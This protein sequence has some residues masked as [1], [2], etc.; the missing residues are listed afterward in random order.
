MTIDSST[1]SMINIL[2]SGAFDCHETAH[3]YRIIKGTIDLFLSL[4]NGTSK[5]YP[6]C[7]FEAGD[8]I[9]GLQGV[10]NDPEWSLIASG[11]SET[12]LE[13]LSF[14][15]L[16]K[17]LDYQK[18]SAHKE[19]PLQVWQHHFLH[20]LKDHK[21]KHKI[22]NPLKMDESLSQNSLFD[23][24]QTIYPQLIKAPRLEDLKA[25][26]HVKALR[27]LEEDEL[28]RSYKDM[29]SII[30][31]IPV[32]HKVSARNTLTPSIHHITDFYNI[33]MPEEQIISNLNDV[34]LAT[35]VQFREISLTGPWW[36]TIT[37]PVLLKDINDEHFCVAMPGRRGDFNLF[38]PKNQTCEKL[39]AETAQRFIP[40]AWQAYH[41][42]PQK[43]LQLKELLSFSIQGSRLDLLR[44]V[45]V[46]SLA[47][48]LALATPWFTSFIFDYI[49]PNGEITQLYQIILGLI[50]AAC[51]SGLFGLV[52]AV[53]LLRLSSKI[54]LNLEVGIW[55]RLIRL[56]VS[57]FKNYT[58]GELVVRAMAASGMRH[59][60]GGVVISSIL[61]GIFSLFSFILLFYYD[62]YLAMIA[63]AGTL[64]LCALT[65][66]ISIRQYKFYKI[67]QDKAAKLSGMVVQL[68]MGIAKIQES[69]KEKMAFAHWA[70]Q[71]TAI[72]SESYKVNWLHTL[73]STFNAAWM[74]LLYLAIFACISTLKKDQLSLGSFLAFNAALGQFTAGMLGLTNAMTSVIGSLPMLKQLT[75]IIENLPEVHSGKVDPGKLKGRISA[76]NLAFRYAENGPMILKSISLSIEA[77]QYIAITGPS[78]SGKSTL[79]RL[80]LGFNQPVHG[81]IFFDEHDITQLNPQRVRQQCGVVLQNSMLMTGS[82]Y[83]NIV[84]SAV[85]S[86]EDAMRA[87]E[88][89]GMREDIEAMPMGL[90]TLVSERGGSLSGGQRQRLL[91]ARALARNPR[92]LFFDEATSALD[93]RTQSIV[94]RS[95][96]QLAVTRIVIAHRLTTIEKADLILVL[97]KGEVV[98]QGTYQELMS[99]PGLFKEMA[100]RQLTT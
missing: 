62:V 12:A 41:P 25:L 98:Q 20:Y 32:M 74:P 4:R 93:N 9:V 23:F 81:N 55:D 86:L 45:I 21:L 69:G 27:H 48:V 78:G 36:R 10:I 18:T 96:E 85:L 72:K 54:N 52:R 64:I 31:E 53:A 11:S 99:K 49:I 61:G 58:S 51:A 67:L 15:E 97:D 91:I 44:M 17:E 94:I 90:H 60:I 47:A 59:I 95:L 33:K 13:L 30:N 22:K 73:L 84:G 56:P 80:L 38:D 82:I 3:H 35:G 50:V 6:I 92:I 2:E 34:S 46:G 100:E 88:K 40:L 14:E 87:A 28:N 1:H 57:F 65:L 43:K 26:R 70:N 77:G 75:P 19:H 89:A 42:L 39:T 76:N 68:L 5:R 71:N 16:I 8:I 79:F 83:E 63:T 66:L 29:L 24:Y 7:R 37:N